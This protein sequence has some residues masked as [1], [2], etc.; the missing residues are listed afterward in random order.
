MSSVPI[1]HM[2]NGADG[3]TKTGRL[4]FLLF[5]TQTARGLTELNMFGGADLIQFAPATMSSLSC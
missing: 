3:M 1:L 2:R 5:C 4:K